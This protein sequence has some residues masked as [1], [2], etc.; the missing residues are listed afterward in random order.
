M[1][2]LCP[3]CASARTNHHHCIYQA[4]CTGCR[5]RMLA[6][7]PHYWRAEREGELTDDYRKALRVAFGKD[8]KA[9]HEQVKEWAK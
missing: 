8:W 2:L 6:S 1:S 4:D 9:G 5:A 3:E 7:G